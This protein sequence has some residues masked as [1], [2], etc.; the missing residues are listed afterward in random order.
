MPAR[1]P[2]YQFR[3]FLRHGELNMFGQFFGNFP[4]AVIRPNQFGPLP[5]DAPNRLLF[6]GSFRMPFKIEFSPALDVHSGFPY[7]KV[8]DELNFVGQRNSQR[9]SSGYS[10]SATPEQVSNHAVPWS[11]PLSRTR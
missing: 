4:S 11:V 10:P 2:F 3:S 9:C 1:D 5:Y 8:D 7:S 6:W